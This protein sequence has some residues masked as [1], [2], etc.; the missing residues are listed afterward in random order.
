MEPIL[1]GDLI[2]Q[3]NDLSEDGFRVLA[4]A[5]IFIVAVSELMSNPTLLPVSAM[6]NCNRARNGP[7]PDCACTN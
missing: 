2:E 6:I 1:V 4:I 3:V 7:Q 5:T